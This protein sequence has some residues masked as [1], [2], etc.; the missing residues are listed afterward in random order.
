MRTVSVYD[1]VHYLKGSLESDQRI[2]N[3][4]VSGEIS[5]FNHHFSGHFYFSIK[6]EKARLNCVMFKSYASRVSF[7][8]KN[9]DKVIIKCNISVFEGTGQMQAYVSDIRL[10]GLGELYMRFEQLKK[11]LAIKGYFNDDH[12]ISFRPY[13]E[14]VAVLVG[15]RSAALSDIKTCFKRRWPICH[16][17]IYPVLVQGEGSAQNIIETLKDVDNLEYDAIIL[18]RGGGSIEDLWSFNDEMLAKTIYELK[19]FI[20][21]GIGHE[22]DFTIADFVADLRAPTPTA[23]VEMIT[24]NIKDVLISIEKD[25]G[26]MT[27]SIRK[28]LRDIDQTFDSIIDSVV[29]RDPYF[30]I[31]KQAQH[32]DNLSYRLLGF[33][34]KINDLHHMIDAMMQNINYDIK[35]MVALKQNDIQN[36]KNAYKVFIK[37][38]IK[39]INTKNHDLN[40]GL[41]ANIK[42]LYKDHC[43]TYRRY[44]T[45]LRA[46]GYESTLKRGFSIVK[47]DGVVIKDTDKL[48]IDD[49]IDID[50]YSGH[51]QAKIKEIKKDGKI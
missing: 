8:P 27:S 38:T 12:K 35:K 19:T 47:K 42:T 45:L 17:D 29:Y 11:D 46:Y 5:N 9:G 37:N 26:K 39:E 51:I 33:T 2:Q 22:Q 50:L 3:I 48:K 25:E 40:D 16:Y 13:I 44:D 43:Q 7:T 1:L 18:A 24:P 32:F 10:D 21:T 36:Y 15:D 49:V 6:D 30:L 28:R 4:L 14:K 41:L 20:V 34:K 23:A 31:Q